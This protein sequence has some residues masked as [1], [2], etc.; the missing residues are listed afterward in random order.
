M[1]EKDLRIFIKAYPAC[2]PALAGDEH[3]RLE[4]S[5]HKKVRTPV[6][7]PE[8]YPFF[9]IDSPVI[10]RLSICF[11]DGKNKRRMKSGS[12]RGAEIKW[13]FSDVQTLNPDNLTHSG[14]V[15]ASPF[16]LLSSPEK[17]VD[18]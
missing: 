8:K 5:A 2:N 16:L 7:V 10:C 15:T 6:S 14:F 11:Y 17:T 18:G 12:V 1:L 3:K 4:L 13:D 9:K